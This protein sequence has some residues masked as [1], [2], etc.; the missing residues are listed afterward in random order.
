[1]T[2]LALLANQPGHQDPVLERVAPETWGEGGAWFNFNDP[3]AGSA[4]PI[5]DRPLGWYFDNE[6]VVVSWSDGA[7]LTSWELR[8]YEGSVVAQ[9]VGPTSPLNLGRP[10]VGWYKLYLTRGT[11]TGLPWRTD[12]GEV[13]FIVSGSTSPLRT[14]PLLP[15]DEK[16]TQYVGGV[17]ASTRAVAGHGM[18]RL[19]VYLNEDN[20][21]AW[22]EQL[23]WAKVAAAESLATL[24]DIEESGAPR[25]VYCHFVEGTGGISPSSVAVQ[26]ITDTVQELVPLGVTYFEGMNE[27]NIRGIDGATTAATYAAFA[28]T[29][30][31]ADP[32]AKVV[33]PAPVTINPTGPWGLEWFEDFLV[34]GGGAHV[35]VVSFHPYN[36]TNNDLDQGRRVYQ[37]FLDLLVTHGVEHKPRWMTEWGT[38]ALPYGLFD[39][40]WQVQTTMLDLH[41]M[42]QILGV[43]R[44]S[45][46]YFY[47]VNNGYWNYP[48]SM[49]SNN[50]GRFNPYALPLAWRTWVEETWEMDLV[51]ALDFGPVESRHWLGSR[52]RH[53]ATGDECLTIQGSGRVGQVTLSVV[54]SASLDVTGHFG[55]VETVSV[56]SGKVV[57]ECGPEPV[58]VR[59]PAG[60]AATVAPVDYGAVVAP[61]GL[62]FDPSTSGNGPARAMDGLLQNS[63][64]Y[65]KTAGQGGEHDAWMATAGEY[66]PAW[67]TARFDPC[68][69]DSV[70]I[71]CPPPWQAN[72]A[73]LDFDVQ[74][75][76]GGRWQTIHTET[77]EPPGVVWA[78]DK[79]TS[80][81]WSDTFWDRRRIFVVRLSGP[82]T[83][84]GL[85]IWA[86]NVSWGG[87][88]TLDA[89][90]TLRVLDA[91]G[92]GTAIGQG[93]PK[94]MALQEVTLYLSA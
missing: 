70:E 37:R 80:A 3:P 20:P 19:D 39:P 43:H 79:A 10:G 87:S 42:W 40:R 89:A 93:G 25:E 16:I 24:A 75:W 11:D 72:G 73:L 48:S 58:H 41:L 55:R 26:Q 4:L 21:T 74:I 44:N 91:N 45:T 56:S 18:I 9:G 36:A 83:T 15:A 8:D 82:V 1:M 29:V 52:F 28:A 34:A 66:L 12:A 46:V 32:A 61:T 92:L 51:E 22:R 54:G 69:F 71:I 5:H 78:S 14:S 68:T 7:D 86:R 53:P 88:A 63:Y 2:L 64:E 17:M 33:G 67:W 50:R 65:G 49:W 90:R 27:P 59:V 85:R 84:S 47:D 6:D 76:L 38:F 62:A 23:N 13:T 57:V 35:D 77:H 30:H 60:V 94:R 81:S 31:A